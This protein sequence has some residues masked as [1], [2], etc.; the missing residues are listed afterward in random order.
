MCGRLMRLGLGYGDV[1]MRR[2]VV[3]DAY[4]FDVGGTHR[5]LRR[6]PGALSSYGW[7]VRVVVPA[8]GVAAD[9]LRGGG[10]DVRVVAA[11]P[12]LLHYGAS[13]TGSRAIRAG[14]ELPRY[15]R[16]CSR[17][18]DEYADVVVANDARGLLLAG[19]AARMAGSRLLWWVHAEPP[20]LQRVLRPLSMLADSVIASSAPLL[21]WSRRGGEVVAP[22]VDMPT[23]RRARR[24][25]RPLIASIARV[26][27]QKGIDVLAKAS[28]RLR[29]LGVDHEVVV[30][31]SSRGDD[32][33]RDLEALVTRLGLDETFTIAGE[34]SDV[35]SLL[36]RAV[37]YAQCSRSAEGFGMATLEAMAHG[38]PVVASDVGGLHDLVADVGL[39]VPA[40]DPDVVA[41]AV[42]RLLGDPALR[43]RLGEAARDRA[44]LYSPEEWARHMA[45]VLDRMVHR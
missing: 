3:F 25:G 30:A 8:E 15:W 23:P 41:A 13:T 5:L 29:D 14:L 6:L 42:H 38:L 11:A 20:Q 21:R 16:R 18:F 9:Y 4:P 33:A 44:A 40:D 19:P 35:A 22:P 17:H 32:A 36:D 45:G 10:V 2:L 24:S 12:G 26:H 34:I 31:G 39:L 43:R 7:S 28:R 37:V 27:P 1:S